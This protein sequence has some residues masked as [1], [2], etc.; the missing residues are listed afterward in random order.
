M[1][2]PVVKRSIVV[3]GHK[4]SVSVEEAFWSGMKEISRARR[5]CPSWLARSMPIATRAI[6]HLRSASSCSNT[7]KAA[8]YD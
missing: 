6:C 7:S 4:T 3:T 2:S 5:R 8:P 1:K